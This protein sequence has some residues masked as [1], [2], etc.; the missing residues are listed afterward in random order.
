MS[1]A[2]VPPGGGDGAASRPAV[3][4]RA[5]A[6][7]PRS[8]AARRRGRW[9]WVPTATAAA[10]LGAAVHRALGGGDVHVPP[11]AASGHVAV[12]PLQ[13][14]IAPGGRAGAAPNADSL[15]GV[16][17]RAFAARG[18]VAVAITINS[19]GGSPVR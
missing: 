5:R 19:P 2:A 1:A 9:S 8:A 4:A 15:R 12:V 16:L 6:G 18:C 17:E 10:A 7:A 14:T 13:G 3:P 11:R